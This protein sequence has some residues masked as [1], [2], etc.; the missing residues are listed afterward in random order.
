MSIDEP[1]VEEPIKECSPAE[2][3]TPESVKTEPASE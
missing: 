3:P 2:A 1:K